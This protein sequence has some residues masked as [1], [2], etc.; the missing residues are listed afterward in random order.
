[1]TSLRRHHGVLKAISFFPLDVV[2]YFQIKP[3]L[4]QYS[5]PLEGQ[6][7]FLVCVLAIL[8]ILLLYSIRNFNMW[9][10][11]SMLSIFII[12]SSNYNKNRQYVSSSF[13][14]KKLLFKT[15][16]KWKKNTSAFLYTI[17]CPFYFQFW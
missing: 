4:Q 7:L 5:C 6:H 12:I 16:V 17:M 13:F 1:M 9:R 2:V 10:F 3:T 8:S 11:L 15:I 14:I